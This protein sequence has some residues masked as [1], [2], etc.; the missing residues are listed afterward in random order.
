M[1]AT[2]LGLPYE[3]YEL[4]NKV[5]VLRVVAFVINLGLVLY[6]VL[7]KRLFGVRGGKKAYEAHLRSESILDAELAV[8]A[9]E[10]DVAVEQEAIADAAAPGAP[11]APPDAPAP[12]TQTVAGPPWPD[13]E[14]PADTGPPGPDAEAPAAAAPAGPVTP[15]KGPAE[16]DTRATPGDPVTTE[17]SDADGASVNNVPPLPRRHPRS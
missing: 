16:P 15:G 7:T 12:E 4:M 3:I 1:I 10:Q 13:A 2:S 11:V 5:T 9:A 8:L 17:A 14:A 6:L